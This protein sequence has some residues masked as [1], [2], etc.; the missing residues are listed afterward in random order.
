M[1]IVLSDMLP[2]I[3]LWL[4]PA[5]EP[6]AWPQYVIHG[7]AGLLESVIRLHLGLPINL[8]SRFERIVWKE[9]R[10]TQEKEA[11]PLPPRLLSSFA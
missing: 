5:C 10:A 9:E 6:F 2:A 11:L 3:S 1:I 8:A 7:V 4:P